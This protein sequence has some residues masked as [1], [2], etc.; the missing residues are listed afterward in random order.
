[1]RIEVCGE[2]SLVKHIECAYYDA[3]SGY[4]IKVILKDDSCSIVSEGLRD[5]GFDGFQCRTFGV[6]VN[7]IDNETRYA[8]IQ[9]IPE[10]LGVE[11]RSLVDKEAVVSP[12]YSDGTR[13]GFAV[14]LTSAPTPRMIVRW[15]SGWSHVTPLG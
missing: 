11:E 7:D 4:R 1:M 13:H 15:S 2:K 10:K 6:T 9:L 3:V 14:S 12:M 5:A 8:Q